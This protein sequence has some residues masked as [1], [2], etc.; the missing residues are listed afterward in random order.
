[1][2]EI[3]TPSDPTLE[4]QPADEPQVSDQAQPEP[5]N[6]PP[7]EPAS[8]VLTGLNLKQLD[9][10]CR[11]PVRVRIPLLGTAKA[12]EV[13]A[14]RLTPAESF[15]VNMEL[16]RALPKLIPGDRPG[17]ERFDLTDPDY[18]RRREEA[19]R[20]ARALAL[21][22][23]VPIFSEAKPGLTSPEAMRDFIEQQ[24]TE[25]ILNALFAAVVP[26]G[27]GEDANSWAGF[28]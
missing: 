3:P 11:A 19:S 12:V 7:A 22:R 4:P 27:A 9:E 1:M 24:L 28:F 23:A 8:E 10:L 2:P 14:R 16:K 26:S 5:T 25:E 6:V 13:V 20:K 21:Y 18:T 17:Q 15:Q